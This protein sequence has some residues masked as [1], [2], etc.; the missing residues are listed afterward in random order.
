M[1]HI[2]PL[3]GKEG[4]RGRGGRGE[5]CLNSSMVGSVKVNS[6]FGRG[7][8][9]ILEATLSGPCLLFYSSVGGVSIVEDSLTFPLG[10]KG[11]LRSRT[12]LCFF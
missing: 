10:E 3:K 6:S 1:I 11:Y 12:K 5:V 2:N 9:Q 8:E 4:N 7:G